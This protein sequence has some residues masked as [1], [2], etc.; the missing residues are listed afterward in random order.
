MKIGTKQIYVVADN[1]FR[2]LRHAA[3]PAVIQ[4]R[5]VTPDMFIALLRSGQVA[6]AIVD[7]SAVTP[8]FEAGLTRL[9]S[10]LR[11]MP[12]IH[13]VPTVVKSEAQHV[14]ADARVGY[15]RTHLDLVRRLKYTAI[16][17]LLAATSREL[18]S[19][20]RPTAPVDLALCSAP[21]HSPPFVS[22]AECA[23]FASC[24]TDT[25]A[26]HWKRFV[27]EAARG[28][29]PITLSL[30][31][32]LDWTVFLRAIAVKDAAHGWDS[33][34]GK[35]GISAKR[36][37]RFAARNCGQPLQL[38]ATEPMAATAHYERAVLKPLGIDFEPSAAI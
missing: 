30:K 6:A 5:I 14:W 25:L 19:R 15:A 17:R 11:V 24:A 20:L 23:T 37:S 33:V 7:E 12:V 35:M 8:E 13:L 26:R 29:T 18:R 38:L 10:V 34:L 32:Y 28:S 1:S 27:A 3:L 2:L 4:D 36:L 21:E 16:D 9:R 31:T 22:V